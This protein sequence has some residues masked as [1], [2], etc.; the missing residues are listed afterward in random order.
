MKPHIRLISGIWCVF[1]TRHSVRPV[2]MTRVFG[3]INRFRVWRK[4][5]EQ[6]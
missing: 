1:L 2:A 6:G 5:H 4:R 3:R